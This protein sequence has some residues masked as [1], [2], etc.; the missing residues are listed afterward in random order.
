MYND[1]IRDVI[2]EFEKKRDRQERDRKKRIEYVYNKIPAIRRLDEEIIKISAS[3]AK[4]ILINPDKYKDTVEQAKEAIESLKMEKAYLLTESNIS[5]DYME[6]KYDCSMCKDTGYLE[7]GDR[8]NC[9]KQ[10]LIN[11]AYKMSNLGNIL[12][13]ENFQT[14]N[15]EIFSNEKFP[16]EDLSPRENMV[17]IAGIA[18]GFISNFD[19]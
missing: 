15:I 16:G 5:P 8:C 19:E 11:R 2:Q 18:E 12:K 14:F 6:L 17:D 7:D 10:E 13:K 9:L 4:N 1:I 3:M